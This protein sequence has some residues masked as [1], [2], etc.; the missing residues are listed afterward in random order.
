MEDIRELSLKIGN[1]V[2]G[3]IVYNLNIADKHSS[4]YVTNNYSIENY[5]KVYDEEKTKEIVET[6]KKIDI[7]SWDQSYF[8]DDYNVDGKHWSVA[9]KKYSGLKESNGINEYPQTFEVLIK[10][11]ED[12]QN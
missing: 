3:F 10:L 5:R 2:E 4:L 12:L 1:F 7:D 9:L 6:I 11:F 8:N